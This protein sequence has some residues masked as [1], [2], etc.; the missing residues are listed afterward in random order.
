MTLHVVPID[1]LKEHEESTTCECTPMITFENGDMIVVHSS[2]DG[3]E[4]GE[5]N[6]KKLK[7]INDDIQSN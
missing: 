6:Y 1:D 5:C 3:R 4:F 2:F 7:N